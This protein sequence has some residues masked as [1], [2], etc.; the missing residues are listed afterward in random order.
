M[1]TTPRRAVAGGCFVAGRFYRGGCFLP[2]TGDVVTYDECRI[3]HE[4]SELTLND[5]VYAR[6]M[7]ATLRGST[8]VR[9][10][11]VLRSRRLRAIARLVEAADH[12]G[13]RR[14]RHRLHEIH[15]RCLQGALTLA[16]S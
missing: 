12:A 15:Q 2:K 4:L 1:K 9:H 13:D 7:A 10:Q 11:V 16:G 5:H 3:K 14:A 6:A 8:A